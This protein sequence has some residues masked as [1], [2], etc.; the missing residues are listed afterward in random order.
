MKITI[1]LIERTTVGDNQVIVNGHH[2]ELAPSCLIRNHSNEFSWGYHG[3]GPAQS[4]LAICL[5]LF[6]PYI[7]PEVYQRFKIEFVGEWKTEGLYTIDIAEFYRTYVEPEMPTFISWW[8]DVVMNQLHQATG[9]AAYL[10]TESI[11]HDTFTVSWLVKEG[12]KELHPICEPLGYTL[13][14]LDGEWHLSAKFPLT[15]TMVGLIVN[16]S[17]DMFSDAVDQFTDVLGVAAK[18]ISKIA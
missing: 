18:N 15:D 11:N 17:A 1:R 12:Y 16:R 10:V 6:G 3:S 14:N 4:A 5:H 2:M 7:A 8:M 13:V 9:E